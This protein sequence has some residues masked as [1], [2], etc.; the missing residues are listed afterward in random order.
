MSA[1]KSKLPN[2]RK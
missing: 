1:Q 2:G